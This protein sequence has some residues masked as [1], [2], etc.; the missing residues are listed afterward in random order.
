LRGRREGRR[1]LDT[2]RP[3]VRLAGLRGPGKDGV[4]TKDKKSV[5]MNCAKTGKKAKSIHTQQRKKKKKGVGAGR[6]F[7][8]LE[9][10]CVRDAQGEGG[11][12]P[13]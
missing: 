1:V 3:P 2:M 11:K 6:N 8:T 13:T 7:H 12:R 9:S 5:C 10:V 4:R